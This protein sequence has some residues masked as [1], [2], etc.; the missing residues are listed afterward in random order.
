MASLMMGNYEPPRSLRPDYPAALETIV[1]RA[2]A[3][4]P[5]ERFQ[6]ADQMRRALED[7]LRQSGAPMGPRQIAALLHERIGAEIA[8]RSHVLANAGFSVRPP[9]SRGPAETGSGAGL[10][11]DRR[12][13]VAPA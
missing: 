8:A 6:T 10:E 11:L 12:P 13:T 4:D 5:G 3:S 9:F 7:Y 2:L 1:V